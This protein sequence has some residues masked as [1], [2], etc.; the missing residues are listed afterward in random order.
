MKKGRRLNRKRMLSVYGGLYTFETFGDRLRCAYCGDVRECVDHV[1]PLYIVDKHGTDELRSMGVELITV[2]CCNPCNQELGARPLATYE[3]RLNFLYL[4]L[5][6]KV[7]NKHGIWSEQE[8]NEELTG[9]LRRMV[10]A[11]HNIFMREVI[12]RL[13]GIE[14]RISSLEGLQT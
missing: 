2:P 6:D 1:P 10:A 13:R 11:K 8:I 12:Q 3:E 9:N 7:E 14:E 5:L 4:R